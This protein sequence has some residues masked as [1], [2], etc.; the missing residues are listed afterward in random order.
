MIDSIGATL[1]ESIDDATSATH[2]IAGDGKTPLRRTPKLMICL[3]H[4]SNILHMDW[5]T[6]SSKV[7]KPLGCD[8]YLLLDDKCAETTYN[9]SMQKT[10]KNID[11]IRKSG[12]SLFFGWSIYICKGVAG[13]KAPPLHELHLIVRA[14]GGNLLSSISASATKR[15]DPNKIIIITSDPPTP[16]QKIELDSQKV[17]LCRGQ[18]TTSWLFHC[19]ITQHIDGLDNEENSVI[20][21][22]EFL[23]S[24]LENAKTSIASSNERKKRKAP[25]RSLPPEQARRRARRK[26]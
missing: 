5:L 22:T 26:T 24:D 25:S 15:L 23:H 1:V 2:V 10:L 20:G 3:C 21:V 13:N 18:R 6:Q 9:F 16:A 12:R 17:S 7:C 19:L 4:T 11:A 8:D 14:A